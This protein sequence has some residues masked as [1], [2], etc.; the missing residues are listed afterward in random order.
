MRACRCKNERCQIR[1]HLTSRQQKS[2][3]TINQTRRKTESLQLPIPGAGGIVAGE[4]IVSGAFCPIV[5]I[6][7]VTAE[8]VRCRATP[9]SPCSKI[10]SETVHCRASRSAARGIV[11]TKTVRGGAP[12]PV[13]A[14]CI[15]TRKAVRRRAMRYL[16]VRY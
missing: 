16:Q 12:A 13:V 6:G 1:A 7:I 15:I 3:K 9:S 11:A 10:T 4:T 8:P 5:A 2:T 14:G